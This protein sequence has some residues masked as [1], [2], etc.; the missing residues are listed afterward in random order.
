METPRNKIHIIGMGPGGEGFLLPIAK[1]AI[2]SADCLIG[3]KRHIQ[4]FSYLKKENIPLGGH[5]SKIMQ[6][7]NKKKKKKMIAILV[8]G[9]PGIYSLAEKLFQRLDK[10]KFTVFPGISS[11]QL[12]FARIGESWQDAKI[13]SLHGRKIDNL[14]KEINNYPKVFLF[15][16]YHLPP[17]KIADYLLK[18]GVQNYRA[19]VLEN[20]SYPNERI[21]DTSL[22]KLAKKT[23]FGLCSMII[24]LRTPNSELRT[25]KSGKLFGIGIGPGDPKLIT[26]KAKEALEGADIIFTPEAR[27]G[28]GSLARSIIQDIITAEKKIVTLAFPMTRDEKKLQ[29]HW[30]SAA[31]KIAREISQGKTACFIT[32]GDPFIYSTYVYLLKEIKT[33]F[34]KIQTET[35]PGISSF[36]AASA[37]AQLPLIKKDENLIILPANSNFERIEKALEEFNTI[38]LMKIGSKLK[39]V[40]DILKKHRLLK[41]STLFS[42][43][44]MPNETI[45][46][47]LNV[48]TS[49]KLG[50]LSLII[51]KK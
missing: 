26:L 27:A 36:S 40:L 35:I 14:V 49:E 33:H 48:R 15:T 21:I 24:K 25:P 34:P 3:A 16:D 42:R 13:I 17:N 28:E 50:Y 2:E 30:E 20:L 43:V 19:I 51:V 12:A 32:L 11:I 44:G 45:V 9:D 22:R 31:F 18:N 23:G 37:R 4:A 10:N 29:T 38:I 6:I 5:L 8:S 46:R 7:N 47:N 41:N 1:K 39:E